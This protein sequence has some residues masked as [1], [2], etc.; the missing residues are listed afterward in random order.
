MNEGYLRPDEAASRLGVSDDQIQKLITGKVV[1]T[2]RGPDGEILVNA[3]EAAVIL[4]ID[5]H[6]EEIDDNNVDL[7]LKIRKIKQIDIRIMRD[8]LAYEEKRGEV[9]PAAEVKQDQ[10]RRVRAVRAAMLALPRELA[11]LLY[12]K[13]VPAIEKEIRSAVTRVIEQFAGK[14]RAAY[15]EDSSDGSSEHEQLGGGDSVRR[16]SP[17]NQTRP[18]RRAVGDL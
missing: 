18:Q 14:R 15:K 16:D 5:I 7:A 17:V 8:T 12:G 13:S 6:L 11:P 2:K 4:G 10:L 9:I 3:A 1:S